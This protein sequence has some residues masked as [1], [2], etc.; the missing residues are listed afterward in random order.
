MTTISKEKAR[1]IAIKL[2]E[3]Q[4]KE[5]KADKDK[6]AALVTDLVEKKIPKDVMNL[7]VKT[8][9]KYFSKQHNMYLDVKNFYD[10]IPFTKALPNG[11]AKFVPTKEVLAL[12]SKIGLAKREKG[13]LQNSIYDALIALK[14]IKKIKA[15]FPEAAKFLVSTPM[16]LTVLKSKL[17]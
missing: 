10:S 11:D 12:A 3:K 8:E 14:T 6:L 1:Q 2:T 17:K 13:N 4:D 15:E 7:F 5:I 9:G 16:D